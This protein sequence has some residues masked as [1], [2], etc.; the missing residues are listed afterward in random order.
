MPSGILIRYLKEIRQRNA[1]SQEEVAQRLATST[2][3]ISNIERGIMKPPVIFLK[4]FCMV[5]NIPDEDMLEMYC[6]YRGDS[7]IRAAK[8]TWNSVI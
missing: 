3:A 8:D 7:A 1:W 4:R 6:R 5:F 2:Q